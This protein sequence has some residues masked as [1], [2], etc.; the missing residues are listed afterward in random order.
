MVENIVK[1]AVVDIAT[2][3]T[4]VYNGPC[5]L[6]AVYVNTALSAHTCLIKDGSTTMLTLPASLAAGSEKRGW[7]AECKSSLVVDPNDAGTG[8]ITVFYIPLD[9]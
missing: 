4:T 1:W 2:D 9:K 7:E 3:A 6:V 8:N 5:A